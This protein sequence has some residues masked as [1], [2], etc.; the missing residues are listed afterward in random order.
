MRAREAGKECAVAQG[1]WC[2]L[3]DRH[4]W[5]SNLIGPKG[6]YDP[7][8]PSRFRNEKKELI[9]STVDNIARSMIVASRLVVTFWGGAVEYAAYIL[10]RT[11]R[12]RT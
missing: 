10:N 5:L 1:H 11:R 6:F 7:E 9:Q 3:A 8:G 12:E 2:E 4:S